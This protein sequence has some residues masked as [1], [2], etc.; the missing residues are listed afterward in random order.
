MSCCATRALILTVCII[1]LVLTFQRQVFDFLG[2]MWAP[3]LG[4]FFQIVFV[5]LGFFGT[6]HYRTRYIASYLAWSLVWIGWNV[7]IICFYLEVGALSR[8]SSILN[9][10]TGSRS[11]WEAN[12]FGCK[13]TFNFSSSNDILAITKP[14]S[15]EGCLLNYFYVECIQAG[16]QCFLAF[17]GF[18]GGCYVIYLY[19]QEDDSSAR[20]K[21]TTQIPPYSIEF[22]ATP[23]TAVPDP[24]RPM[25][26]RRV[27][28]RSTR[29]KRSSQRYKNP[30]T[31]LMDRSLD[32]SSNDS[33]AHL[34]GQ[35]N[36]VYGGS[37]SSL[38]S[39]YGKAN[40]NMN[41]A[42]GRLPSSRGPP[43]YMNSSETVI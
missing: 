42:G 6:Y 1:Q 33:Y 21:R 11:W 7:F 9:I 27:K 15:V 37:R 40:P 14:V 22:R 18:V 19:N 28:R 13:A 23:A 29:S 16:V 3:I 34:G 8:D 30:V 12:G 43:V 17:I 31:R 38:H 10:G 2:Y 35:C 36:P 24:L 39:L 5:I 32:T 25:T 4:N 26:P 41:P 20:K